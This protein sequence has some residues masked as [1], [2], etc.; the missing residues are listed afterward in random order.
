MATAAMADVSGSARQLP[1][2][3]LIIDDLGN[4]I[5]AGRRVIHLDGPVALSIL[6]HTPYAREIAQQAHE[7]GKEVM[8][9]LPLQPVREF[10]S[11]G[12]GAIRLET[13]RAQLNRILLA[14][15][16]SV[17]YI[18]G[19]NNHMG[20]LITQ[21]PGHM[22]WLMTG[23]KAYGHLFFVDSFTSKL[24]VALQFAREQGIPSTRRDV[25]LDNDPSAAAI[26]AEFQRLERVA[27]ERGT[28][29]GIGHPNTQT[30]DFL[31]TEL[32][33]LSREGYRLVSVSDLIAIQS[34]YGEP[35][36]IKSSLP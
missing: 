5:H 1:R 23:L 21:H 26:A 14:D 16:N 2:I 22:L 15:L 18:V 10:A 8:L 3:A 36:M 11:P 6:P 24:S 33:R 32:P 19:V 25:F 29:V 31:E 28:A 34:A 27:R 12:I 4:L 13:S 7:A 9:H 30:L 35:H 17:P 20:S